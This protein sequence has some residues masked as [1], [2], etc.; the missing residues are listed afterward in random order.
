MYR[1]ERTLQT[2]RCTEKNGHFRLRD[3]QKRRDTLLRAVQKRR[4]TLRDLQK[5]EK[6]HFTD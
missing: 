6:G 2:K 1:K 4:D 3:V 5:T